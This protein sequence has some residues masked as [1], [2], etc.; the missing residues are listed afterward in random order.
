MDLPPFVLLF[1]LSAVVHFFALWCEQTLRL[2]GESVRAGAATKGTLHVYDCRGV[3]WTTLLSDT[4][5]HWSTVSRVFGIGNDHWPDLSSRYFVIHAPFAVH[6]AWKLIA[7]LASEGTRAKVSFC[8]GVPPELAA[9]LGG[10][11]AVQRMLECS[12][13]IL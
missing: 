3:S 4:R 13:H 8:K 2:F 9:A 10:E 5:R 1:A 7:P 12:P 6:Y 11:D